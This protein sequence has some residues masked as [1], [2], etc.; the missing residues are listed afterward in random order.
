MRTFNPVAQ[1]DTLLAHHHNSQLVY[2]KASAS[3]FMV[4]DSTLPF[5]ITGGDD[6]WGAEIE[7]N[8]GTALESGNPNH[9]FDLNKIFVSSVS[10]AN[11]LTHLRFNINTPGSEVACTFTSANNTVN[12]VGHGL[13]DGEKVM[14][15]SAVSN[16]GMTAEN[17]YTVT[18]KA[19]DTFKLMSNG[20]IVDIAGADGAGVYFKVTQTAMTQLPVSKIAQNADV[21]SE[22]VVSPRVSC[23][24]RISVVAKSFAGSTIAVGFVISLH[25]YDN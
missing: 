1:T 12:H 3:S 6:I 18:A 9:Y 25:I 13:L 16:S 10:A 7:I 5:T 21:L 15:K 2:G 14:I 22:E 8:N 19:A 17:V 11:K 24:K 23:D 4:K 20:A